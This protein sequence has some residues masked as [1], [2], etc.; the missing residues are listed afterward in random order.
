MSAGQA[1]FAKVI[2]QNIPKKFF[3]KNV[4][5]KAKKNIEI[6]SKTLGMVQGKIMKTALK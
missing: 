1:I 6:D 4:S 3:E 2:S 5:L